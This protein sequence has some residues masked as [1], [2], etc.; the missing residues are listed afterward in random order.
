MKKR[1]LASIAAVAASGAMALSG[2]GVLPVMAEEETTEAADEDKYRI[3]DGDVTLSIYCDFQN[4]ARAYY[5][6][7][8]DN[9]VVKKIEEQT[10]LNFTFIHAP[11][12]D[13]GSYFQQLLAS[14]DIPDLMFTNEFQ[15]SYPGGVEGAIQ[16]G[17][18]MDI[19]DLVEQYGVNF[20]ALCDAEDDPDIEKKIRGDEGD[21]IKYG[22]IFLP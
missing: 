22:T 17:I 5:N 16:D 20:K 4:A 11:A 21:I 19:T 15:N 2:M 7:L 1:S 18:L 6:D 10:G 9:P 14:G 12:G 13:D 8:G 3:A